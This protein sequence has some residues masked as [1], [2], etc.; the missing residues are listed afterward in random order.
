MCFNVA[1]TRTLIREGR[2]M[3]P[4]PSLILNNPPRYTT[5]RRY[6]ILLQK[7]YEYVAT[8]SF[9]LLASQKGLDKKNFM[10]ESVIGHWHFRSPECENTVPFIAYILFLDLFYDRPEVYQPLHPRPVLYIDLSCF[11]GDVRTYFHA[12]YENIAGA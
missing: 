9:D 8:S 7:E 4:G 10:V 6:T 1:G 12:R 2:S 11:Y 3:P 5:V